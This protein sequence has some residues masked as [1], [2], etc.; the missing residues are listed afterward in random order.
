MCSEGH[1]AMAALASA[2]NI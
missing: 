1:T 2:I